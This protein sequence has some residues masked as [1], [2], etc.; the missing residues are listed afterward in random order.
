MNTHTVK[1]LKEIPVKTLNAEMQVRYW[2][3]GK[4]NG[5]EDDDDNPKIPLRRGEIWQLF[6]DLET[7][8]IAGW[9]KGVTA[10][11]H[12]K[13][14]DAGIYRLMNDA[15]VVAVKDGYVPDMLCPSGN[16][17]GD[18]VIMKIDGN[19]QIENWNADLSYFDP[20]EY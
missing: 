10:E 1:V 14:C 12:Y 5:V 16:G 8:M 18:Y 19:G 6:I 9:P 11:T 17:F 2:E 7:G 13:V 20:D 15:E 4:I 3:D